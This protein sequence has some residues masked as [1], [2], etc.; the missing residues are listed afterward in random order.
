MLE[1][2]DRITQSSI[3]RRNFLRLGVAVTA[4]A[5]FPRPLREMDLIL[6][7][8]QN[9]LREVSLNEITRGEPAYWDVK[10]AA[11][12][13]SPQ[14]RDRR[15]RVGD[16]RFSGGDDK[17]FRQHASSAVLIAGL[18]SGLVW[19]ARDPI[20]AE[21]NSPRRRPVVGHRPRR[22]LQHRPLQQLEVILQL[23]DPLR[24]GP[25]GYTSPSSPLRGCQL[26]G[27]SHSSS[28]AFKSQT[29]YL[30]RQ[31][32]QTTPTTCGKGVSRD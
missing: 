19:R 10:V 3:S 18:P 2:N 12:E 22:R 23:R 16:E 6:G 7:T 5:V 24:T 20:D 17:P 32:R 14:R 25:Q 9:G 21:R 28:R 1:P 26:S 4:A 29:L 8:R 31:P 27:I 13:P 11:H 30:Y 15:F